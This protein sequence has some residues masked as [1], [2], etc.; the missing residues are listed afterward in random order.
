[1][2]RRAQREELCRQLEEEELRIL[3]EPSPRT[4]QSTCS[5]GFI[6]I[7]VPSECVLL[8]DG[9]L[10]SGVIGRLWKVPE[11]S[12]GFQR[13]VQPIQRCETSFG[14]FHLDDWISSGTPVA[15]WGWRLEIRSHWFEFV[16]GRFWWSLG[17]GLGQPKI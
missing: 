5:Q 12:G 8:T 1:M 13:A 14:G 7:F 11:V 15:G 6:P 3:A 17:F 9:R 10:K 2:T 4:A 16:F